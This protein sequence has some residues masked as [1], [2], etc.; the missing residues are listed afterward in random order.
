MT[1]ASR[2][3]ACAILLSF[4]AV[5]LGFGSGASYAFTDSAA[6]DAGRLA[7]PAGSGFTM[8]GLLGLSLLWRGRKGASAETAQPEADLVAAAATNPPPEPVRAPQ[9]ELE[10]IK[11]DGPCIDDATLEN[12]RKLGGEDFVKEVMSQFIPRAC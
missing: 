10:L 12:L 5:L 4:A 3:T 11:L 2:R 7:M 9:P 6:I 1:A 8:A